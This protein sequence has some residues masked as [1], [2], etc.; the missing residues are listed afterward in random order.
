MAYTKQGFKDG[1]VLTAAQL[2]AME[3]A[4]IDLE[5]SLASLSSAEGVGF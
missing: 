3:D 1:E 2:T 4:I 5:N